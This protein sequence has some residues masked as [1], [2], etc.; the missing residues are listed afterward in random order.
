MFLLL[1]YFSPYVAPFQKI[2][3]YN[4]IYVTPRVIFSS[5]KYI[6]LQGDRGAIT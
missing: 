2:G 3:L 5:S 6:D 1:L 4:G